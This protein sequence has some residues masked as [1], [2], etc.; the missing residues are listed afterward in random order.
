MAS[1][2]H[3]DN[4]LITKPLTSSHLQHFSWVPGLGPDVWGTR[5]PLC[6]RPLGRL[7]GHWRAAQMAT[8]LREGSVVAKWTEPDRLYG[9]GGAH[10]PAKMQGVMQGGCHQGCGSWQCPAGASFQLH[11]IDFSWG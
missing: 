10:G 2:G 11:D 4:L 1:V 9:G 8:A 6:R 5:H 7:V 3:L